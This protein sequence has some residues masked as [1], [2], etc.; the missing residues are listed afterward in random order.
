MI[1]TKDRLYP[2]FNRTIG[3]FVFLLGTVLVGCNSE[4]SLKAEKA[5]DFETKA[6]FPQM[7][8][9]TASTPAPELPPTSMDEVSRPTA[10]EQTATAR[11]LRPVERP[12][13]DELADFPT[14][15]PEVRQAA[16]EASKE[17]KEYFSDLRDAAPEVR[18]G[19]CQRL[20]G[21]APLST[22][23]L[24]EL[25][26]LLSDE[27]SEVQYAALRAVSESERFANSRGVKRD[28]S[29]LREVE[30]AIVEGIAS[31][32]FDYRGPRALGDVGGTEALVRAV[33]HQDKKVRLMALWGLDDNGDA[34][35]LAL[36]APNVA[37][38]DDAEIRRRALDYLSA[39][40]YRVDRHRHLLPVVPTLV[41]ILERPND[42][43]WQQEKQTAAHLIARVGESGAAAVPHLV[44]M[45]KEQV[46]D[47]AVLNAIASI[48]PAASPAVPVI[49]ERLDDGSLN[50][51]HKWAIRALGLIGPASTSA[52]DAILEA[53]GANEVQQT[54]VALGRIGPGAKAGI[55]YLIRQLKGSR[56]TAALVYGAGLQRDAARSLGQ[57]GPS[58]F[59]SLT[60]LARDGDKA[61]AGLIALAF[62]EAGEPGTRQL[63]EL[64]QNLPA[65]RSSI[66]LEWM[67]KIAQEHPEKL[68]VYEDEFRVLLASDDYRVR[69]GVLSIL[70]HYTG[71]E[72]ATLDAVRSLELDA[73][74]RQVRDLAKQVVAN[75]AL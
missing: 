7:D 72:A 29:A 36:V 16:V 52:V 34:E 54:T 13:I 23:A 41:E 63:F 44:L 10:G 62:V 75:D 27:S 11:R 21:L 49:V 68:A 8:G 53:A 30:K 47:F 60:K 51:N 45:L 35:G 69:R 50:S 22:A 67:S 1:C 20:E 56:G 59:D 38:D 39:A 70:V 18:V 12:P 66:A 25:Q 14:P 65:E 19:A 57:V 43:A 64:I 32:T 6:N 5:S 24:L 55:P 3:P 17:E 37:L 40:T 74:S 15:E 73:E 58:C 4:T 26:P 28:L 42:R 33:S 71:F 2:R 9:G 61:L 31:G 48:G 46:A